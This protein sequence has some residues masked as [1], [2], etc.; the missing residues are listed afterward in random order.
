[1]RSFFA[2]ALIAFLSCTA[3]SC[4]KLNDD[5]IVYVFKGEITS[6]SEFQSRYDLWLRKNGMTDSVEMRKNFLYGEL[7]DKLLYETGIKD[8][9]EYIPE[10]RNK[11]EDFKK[12]TIVEHM[13]KKTQKEI[14]SIDDETV[15][16]YYLENKDLFLR[17]R[18]H[19]L[20]AVRV[21]NKKTAEDIAEQLRKGGSIRLLSARFST[22][23][24]L[25]RNNGDWGLFS[26][27]VMDELWK[28]DILAALPGQILGPY[29]DSEN[30][31]TIIEI[32]GYAYK[33]HLSF[34]RAYPLIIEKLVNMQSSEKWENYRDTMIREYGAK[35]NLDNLNWE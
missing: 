8:G 11:I 15:R 26:E 29:L 5:T 24:A 13:K 7:S 34:N 30:Y 12:K 23:E 32:A 33:R 1:M 4:S 27:D 14:Y 25:S 2:G 21:N 18:L 6:I 31:Y 16:S 28:K 17:D 20:Y 10:V 3:L 9:V 35:I 19:R 22:D